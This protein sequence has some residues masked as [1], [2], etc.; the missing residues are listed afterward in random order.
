[1]EQ[2]STVHR[3]GTMRESIVTTVDGNLFIISTNKHLTINHNEPNVLQIKYITSM[4][5]TAN[6]NADSKIKIA[7]DITNTIVHHH[8]HCRSVKY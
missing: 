5:L 8:R 2:Y 4:H 1:M 6:I 3:Y 7:S